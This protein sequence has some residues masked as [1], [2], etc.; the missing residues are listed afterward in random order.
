MKLGTALNEIARSGPF[1]P[2][3]VA[4]AMKVLSLAGKEANEILLITK[5]IQPRGGRRYKHR[6]GGGRSSFGDGCFRHWCGRPQAEHHRQ[7]AAMS[8]SSVESIGEAFKTASVLNK[9]FG[10]GLV[11]VGAGLAS[12]SSLGIQGTAAGVA[13]RNMYVDLAGRTP[14]AAGG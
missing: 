1:G 2:L 9:Q 12:L 10:V 8:K 11:D 7:D 3:E 6:E 14:K 4:N 5:D 13:L